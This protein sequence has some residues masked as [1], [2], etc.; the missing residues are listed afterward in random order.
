[1]AE[2]LET[3]WRPKTA[4]DTIASL[5][6]ESA[7]TFRDKLRSLMDQKGWSIEET[8]KRSGL[9]YSSIKSYC[10]KGKGSRLP[11]L[12]SAVAL[13]KA[14]GHS[15]SVFEDCEDVKMIESEKQ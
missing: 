7:M 9:T 12:Q 2:V 6:S 3:M 10:A 1:M 13:A 8:A 15:V 4:A 14:F 5:R 11:N